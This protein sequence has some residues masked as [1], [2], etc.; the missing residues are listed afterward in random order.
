MSVG[1][2]FSCP[3]TARLRRQ[4]LQELTETIENTDL[5]SRPR[6]SHNHSVSLREMANSICDTLRGN[7]YQAL[8]VGGC[9][10]DLLLGLEP[11]DYDVTTNATPEQGR[12]CSP[13][14]S[15]SV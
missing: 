13:R 10:R 15:R 12:G 3:R 1:I 7:G 6:L 5:P 11:A 14:A 8:L 9:V 2:S 4:A